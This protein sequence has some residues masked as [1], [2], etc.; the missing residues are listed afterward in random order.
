[1]NVLTSYIAKDIIKGALI[2]MLLLLTLFNLFTL[3][4]ELDDI[5]KGDYGIV[6]VFYFI[7]LT[8]PT[9]FYELMPAAALLGS[10]FTLGT[11][12]NHH[13]LIAMRASGMTVFNIINAAMVAGVV[14][15]ALAIGVGEFIAPVTE[16]QAQLLRA[17]A[18]H[19]TMI[20]HTRY[21]IWLRE[22][23]RFINIRELKDDGSLANI[24]IYQVDEHQ[25]LTQM[26]HAEQAIYLGQQQWRLQNLQRST[27][28][29]EHTQA[30]SIA[31]ELWT[32]SIAP[33][34]LKI[35]IVNPD[36]LSLYDLALYTDFLKHNGQ[37]SHR[38]EAAFWGRIVNPLVIFVMLLV[39]TPFVIGVKRGVTAGARILIGV[40]IGLSFN[41]LDMTVSHVGL[42]YDLNPALMAFLPSVTVALIGVLAVR[43]V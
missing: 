30:D 40:V 43:K 14:L 9:I 26:Q 25:Q 27:L 42:I 35:A 38:F 28:A 41:V 29:Q 18:Q 22:G 36:N 16:S 32:S 33:D 20:T 1:M 39:S 24:S 21:G 8:S 5:G 6:G 17:T 23:K 31:N 4:D 3:S 19:K 10:L 37:K 13:E 15:A 7:A 34:L 2:A 12:A 11:K